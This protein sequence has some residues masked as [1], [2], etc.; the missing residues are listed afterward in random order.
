M[1]WNEDNLRADIVSVWGEHGAHVDVFDHML[2]RLREE[3][4]E[5]RYVAGVTEVDCLRKLADD[6]EADDALVLIG[7][8]NI[9][10]PRPEEVWL[11]AVLTHLDADG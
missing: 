8:W 9:E 1:T 7:L 2:K 10:P 11:Q 3:R 5:I 4:P 6:L